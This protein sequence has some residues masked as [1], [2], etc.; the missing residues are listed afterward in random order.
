MF[1]TTQGA[2]TE[3]QEFEVEDDGC[4]MIDANGDLRRRRFVRSRKRFRGIGT[5]LSSGVSCT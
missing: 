1:L 5:M 2:L 4:F 3:L